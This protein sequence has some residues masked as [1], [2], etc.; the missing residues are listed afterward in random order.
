MKLDKNGLLQLREEIR[1][2]T[3][4]LESARLTKGQT[5]SDDTN[6]WHDNAAYDAAKLTV[7]GLQYQLSSLKKELSEVTLIS[8]HGDA[9]RVDIGDVVVLYNK[10]FDDRFKVLLTANYKSNIGDDDDEISIISINSPIGEAIFGKKKGDS[11]S[12]RV[13]D[14]N[15]EVCIE[16]F[17][18]QKT[19]NNP[20]DSREK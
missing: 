5:F 16:G 1:I 11:V 17:E 3:E 7:D 20:T 2:I 10:A 15:F 12:Y 13:G 14:R 6:S 8:P 18:K 4:Q 19:S 9:D